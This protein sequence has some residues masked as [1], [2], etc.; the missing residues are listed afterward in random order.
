MIE[1]KCRKRSRNSLKVN[2]VMNC[3]K[4]EGCRCRTIIG[5]GKKEG[6]K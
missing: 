5:G 2:E 3:L 6:R 1:G 4:N